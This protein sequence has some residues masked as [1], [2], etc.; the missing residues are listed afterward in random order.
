MTENTEAVKEKKTN[1]IN[2]EFKNEEG[3]LKVTEEFIAKLRKLAK[4]QEATESVENFINA[5]G[6]DQPPVE[7]VYSSA[8]LDSCDIEIED[9]D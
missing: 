6:V 2:L 4:R 5:L 1:E 9:E 8:Q 3:E 7:E